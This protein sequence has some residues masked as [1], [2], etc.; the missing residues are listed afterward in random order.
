LDEEVKEYGWN[1]NLEGITELY[2]EKQYKNNFL[3]IKY[4]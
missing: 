1:H 4:D 3:K 2:S